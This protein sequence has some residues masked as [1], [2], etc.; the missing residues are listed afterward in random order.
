MNDL[1]LLEPEYRYHAERTRRAAASRSAT[2]AGVAA[3]H[4]GRPRPRSPT[5]R[6]GSAEVM[7]VVHDI[8]DRVTSDPGRTRC[9]AGAPLLHARH[10]CVRTTTQPTRAAVLLAGDAGVGKTRLLTE[11]RDRAVA[12]GW[13]VLAGHCLDFADSALPY[14]PF[15]EVTRPHRRATCPTSSTSVADAPPRAAPAPA[16]PA[17]AV[18]RRTDP[19]SGR[20]PTRPP[21]STACTPS[22]EAAAAKAPLLL[23]VEDPHWADQ[24]TRD[25][26]SFLFSAAFDGPVALVA[27]YRSDDLHRRHPLRR[28]VAEWSRM[29][30]VERLQLEPL[31]ADRRTRAWSTSST[32][33][34]SPE[35]RVARHRRPRRGQR[36]LRRGARR[37][38][39]GPRRLASPTTS[40]TCCWS[41]STGSTTPPV[42]SSAP[43]PSPAAGSP[44]PRSARSS[45]L[46]AGRP[47]PGACATPSRGTCWCRADDDY[48]QFRHALLGEAVYDD[49]LPG[50]RTR[51]HA[52]YAAAPCGRA[53]PR[54]R[55]RAGPARPPGQGLRHRPRRQ[56]PRRRRGPGVG[57]PEEAA[58][59]YLQALEL[60]ARHPVARRQPTST[61]PRSSGSSPTP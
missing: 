35:E 9:R 52:A 57:G 38:R 27:S 26:L 18:A 30:G 58:H 5:R 48:Y 43:P 4:D 59:H 15:S 21:C 31:A 54:H 24:S 34:R 49:L 41:G 61:S 47:R 42:R 3:S 55:R 56:H 29:R 53:A 17:D 25:L 40:P 7:S 22:L 14:L 37:R 36:V 19:E 16:R 12:E 13:Q 44:T 46:P 11:L 23:V 50:E 51:L 33:T 32:P 45:T 2:A 20:R 10:L 8:M 39:L 60:L 1:F 6:T 28:Q